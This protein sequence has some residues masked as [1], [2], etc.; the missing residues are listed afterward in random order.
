MDHYLEPLQLGLS[1]TVYSPRSTSDSEDRGNL[2]TVTTDGRKHDQ[3]DDGRAG[4]DDEFADD[5]PGGYATDEDIASNGGRSWE[6]FQSPS[7]RGVQMDDEDRGSS[8]HRHSNS[9]RARSP[10][11]PTSRG[12]SPLAPT[13]QRPYGT[14]AREP[15]LE[16]SAASGPEPWR[17]ERADEHTRADD[18]TKTPVPLSPS[19]GTP[20]QN[21][22]PGSRT[23]HRRNMSQETLDIV[24]SSG[25]E[26][27]LAS[28][29]RFPSRWARLGERKAP[30]PSLRPVTNEALPPANV[31]TGIWPWYLDHT[32]IEDKETVQAWNTDLDAILIFAALFSSVL[33]TFI[34][35]S[36]QSLRPDSTSTT[37]QAILYEIQVAR[38]ASTLPPSP[39]P[40]SFKPPASAIRVNIYWFSSLIISLA[41]A[42]ITILAKQWVN[43]LLAGLS[44]SV[45]ANRARLRQYRTDGVHR[46]HLP[47][48]LS[49]LPILLHIA[50]LLFFAGLVDFV[51]DINKNVASIAAFLVCTTSLTD[52]ITN[53]LAYVY[54]DCPFKTSVTVLFALM[55][56]LSI[57][58]WRRSRI[59]V[60]DVARALLGLWGRAARTDQHMCRPYHRSNSVEDDES[61]H[62]P[63][64]ATTTSETRKYEPLRISS[65]WSHDERFIEE[66]E[67]ALDARILLW[68]M[69]NTINTNHAHE[70]ERLALNHAFRH[71][72]HVALHRRLLVKQGAITLLE[73]LL[74]SWVSNTFQMLS[75]QAASYA[76]HSLSVLKSEGTLCSPQ[77]AVEDT[78]LSSDPPPFFM[79]EPTTNPPTSLLSPSTYP[80]ITSLLEHS[81]DLHP[82]LLASVIRLSIRI[83]KGFSGRSAPALRPV[84]RVVRH[85]IHLIKSNWPER[86][87][88]MPTGPNSAL[89]DHE[90]FTHGVNT[91]IYLALHDTWYPRRHGFVIPFVYDSHVWLKV[92]L[93]LI[94]GCDHLS[95]TDR[96]QLYWAICALTPSLQPHNLCEA[97]VEPRIPK[98]STVRPFARRLVAL[99]SWDVDPIVFR[100]TVAALEDLSKNV[101]LGHGEDDSKIISQVLSSSP[102]LDKFLAQLRNRLALGLGNSSH[103]LTL[104]DIP[105]PPVIRIAVYI[106]LSHTVA[107]DRPNTALVHNILVVLSHLSTHR[108]DI[109][110]GD[111]P[112]SSPGS[113]LGPEF[114]ADATGWPIEN[115]VYSMS[116]HISALL[117]RQPDSGSPLS[118]CLKDL[119]EICDLDTSATGVADK[120]SLALCSIAEWRSRSPSGHAQPPLCSTAV[121]RSPLDAITTV[122]GIHSAKL[123]WRTGPPILEPFALILQD[124]FER[125]RKDMTSSPTPI[126]S[127]GG[128]LHVVIQFIREGGLDYLL[129]AS[130]AAPNNAL[131]L[132]ALLP[133]LRAICAVLD[134][135]AVQASALEHRNDLR[136]P[137]YV[138]AA[139]LD[140]AH[141]SPR[142]REVRSERPWRAVLDCAAAIYGAAESQTELGADAL[143]CLICTSGN[144]SLYTPDGLGTGTNAEYPYLPVVRDTA[145]FFTK[146]LIRKQNY[147]QMQPTV[148]RYL[149]GTLGSFA[150]IYAVSS[151]ELC[152]DPDPGRYFRFYTFDSDHIAVGL[153]RA[154]MLR[155]GIQFETAELQLNEHY[156]Y[157][158]YSSRGRRGL[159]AHRAFE[160]V[161][162]AALRAVSMLWMSDDAEFVALRASLLREELALKLCLRLFL[163]SETSEELKALVDEIMARISLPETQELPLP[164]IVPRSLRVE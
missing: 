63:L 39:T 28:G 40:Q 153:V 26:G 18:D 163:S 15:S 135:G 12:A 124:V 20:S 51:W 89:W 35:E 30:K 59:V 141:L 129:D 146:L 86:Y 25:S 3:A 137:A 44:R 164:V 17:A 19:R 91:L 118:R 90:D 140:D 88:Q 29:Q 55:V 110:R 151:T 133:A 13:P 98:L 158:A 96:R 41:T 43:Y 131:Y 62:N 152:Q 77:S 5:D 92:M 60:S 50:L 145:S 112:Y 138:L 103:R 95:R 136:H 47:A 117:L 130:C 100:I 120:L 9:L 147:T 46:W 81:D 21:V 75:V 126:V 144:L 71:F 123:E 70:S 10:L 156:R 154:L 84:H 83:P 31:M 150:T 37:L 87:S 11:A 155:P 4:S 67:S 106:A 53:L 122:V 107:V 69:R 7:E 111:L 33:T 65:L 132:G 99:L 52:V 48:V 94:T 119:Q 142:A 134:S 162:E 148:R 36:Y 8:S 56:D 161:S 45:P 49:V 23:G 121:I 104:A 32:L 108:G 128:A 6:W 93:E 159:G 113:K 102:I 24:Y 125:W 79:V 14:T 16:A 1:T 115:W 73:R 54:P 149:W 114:M 127:N 160:R 42:L 80:I 157:F 64:G 57:V 27:G 97:I 66:N 101:K 22:H 58:S 105:L 82:S 109:D 139:A 85:L 143:V 78:V 2:K 76:I 34:I 68:L 38:N 74:Q 116:G 61:Q 72:P